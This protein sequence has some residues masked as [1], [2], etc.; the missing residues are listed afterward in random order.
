MGFHVAC[1]CEPF[2]TNLTLKGSLTGMGAFV[3]FKAARPRVLLSAYLAFKW[4][5]SRVDKNVCLQMAFRDE[6]LVAAFK[7]AN[8]RPIA[9]MGSHVG[10]QISCLTE[11]LQAFAE[12]A[13]Q[14]LINSCLTPQDLDV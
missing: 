6:A 1:F 11:L 7:R 2:T 5:L 3:N 9:C 14:E 12:R 4:F 13:K 8:K 10:L